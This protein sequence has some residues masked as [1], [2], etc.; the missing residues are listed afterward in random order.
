MKNQGY[1]KTAG[2]GATT[3]AEEI[4][5]DGMVIDSPEAA[6]EHMEKFLFPQWEGLKRDLEANTEAEVTKR[7]AG[8]VEVQRLFDMNMLKGPYGGFF[9]FPAFLYYH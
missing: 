4:V 5:C 3:G 2:R 1:E 6:V 8:E 7:I 9:S